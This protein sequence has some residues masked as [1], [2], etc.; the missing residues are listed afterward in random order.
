[1]FPHF[2]SI[3]LFSVTP[4]CRWENE[5]SDPFTFLLPHSTEWLDLNLWLQCYCGDFILS[6]A[7]ES[8]LRVSS[9]VGWDRIHVKRV[10]CCLSLADMTGSRHM[11]LTPVVYQDYWLQRLWDVCNSQPINLALSL[12]LEKVSW[13]MGHESDVI[14]RIYFYLWMRWTVHKFQCFNYYW[15]QLLFIILVE[16]QYI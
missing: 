6:T 16:R 9:Q 11:G 14:I 10:S 8:T 5:E 13:I 3:M 1:M 15:K 4:F 7:R 2:I 12:P